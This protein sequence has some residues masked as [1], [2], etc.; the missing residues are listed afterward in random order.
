FSPQIC[1]IIEIQRK[2]NFNQVHSSGA[3]SFC[4]TSAVTFI[5]AEYFK[6]KVRKDI[7]EWKM[8]Y[9]HL[10][11]VDTLDIDKLVIHVNDQH[12]G[13]G[14]AKASPEV[15]NTIK[16]LA[17]TEGLFL[18]PVYSGKAFHGLAEE[19]KAG[20]YQ[21]ADD[22]VFIHTGGLFGLFAQQDQVRF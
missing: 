20:R 10:S 15:F 21:D 16:S 9:K 13:P 22:I 6:M 3:G 18:D 14:Y 12:I 5:D 8:A 11:G 2:R 7:C 17:R 19:I 1:Y 4:F